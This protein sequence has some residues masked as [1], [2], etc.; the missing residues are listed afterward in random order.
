MKQ[1]KVRSRIG[2]EQFQLFCEQLKGRITHAEDEISEENGERQISASTQEQEQIDSRNKASLITPRH[3]PLILHPKQS[4]AWQ[5]IA[6]HAVLPCGRRSGK[7]EI[8]KRRTV[9]CAAGSEW[10]MDSWFVLAAPTHTQAKRIF[11]RDI[12]RLI[13]PW[14][15]SR[16]SESE[17]SVELLNGAE[18]TI[19]GMDA[20]ERIEGRPLN[21]LG[22]DEYGNM[23]A[24]VW[25]EHARPALVDRQ[26]WAWFTGVPE[27]RNHYYDIYTDARGRKGWDVFHWTT[28]DILPMY[29]GQEAADA[30]I[31]SA[32]A[33]MDELTFNQE[34]LASFISFHGL[35]YYAFTEDNIQPTKY[36]PDGDLIIMM[37][38]NVSPGVAAIGQEHDGR[39][40][41]IGEVYIP[42]NSN[43]LLVCEKI[44]ADWGGHRGR[45]LL[46]GD[47]T[48]GAGGTAKVMGNDWDLAYKRLGMHF[49]NV[50][51]RVPKANPRERQRVNAVNSRLH[52][53]DGNRKLLVDPRATHVIKDFE[54]VRVV[55]GSAGDID[56]KS[57]PKL[58]H[59]TDGIGYYVYRAHPTRR[60]ATATS[61]M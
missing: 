54:G 39:T 7:T 32:K 13:P 5:S 52:T 22:L 35:V 56:K 55:E 46:Y 14:M 38:F 43:T 26:G 29:L 45:V 9:L 60:A 23:K 53:M 58:T 3:T 18:I 17:L 42:R 61:S 36:D 41:I 33:D 2:P 50:S 11:W 12:K 57:D 10:G 51:M 59:I 40:H 49:S 1:R 6:R 19:M 28:V 44:I 16:V 47:A 30:E 8:L 4:A 24:H 21:G 25:V 20:P 27:G 48:G 15:V 31:E 34:F 37:D